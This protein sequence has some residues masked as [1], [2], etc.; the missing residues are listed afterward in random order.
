MLNAYSVSYRYTQTLGCKVTSFNFTTE[1]LKFCVA[2][3]KLPI[4][5][6]IKDGVL[7]FK[8]TEI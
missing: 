4:M 2:N 7:G 6:W 8:T 5:T 3:L 1:V